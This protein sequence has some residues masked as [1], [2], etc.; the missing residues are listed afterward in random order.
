[1]TRL[2]RAG[3]TRL[4]MVGCSQYAPFR[5]IRPRSR[6]RWQSSQELVRWR[7]NSDSGNWKSSCRV[8]YPYR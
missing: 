6:F 1:M 4:L 2:Y 8:I 3:L 5:L 7:F